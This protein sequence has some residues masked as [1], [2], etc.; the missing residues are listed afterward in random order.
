MWEGYDDFKV[1]KL[2]MECRIREVYEYFRI[3][4]WSLPSSLDVLEH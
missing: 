1:G 4:S 2:L 3:V